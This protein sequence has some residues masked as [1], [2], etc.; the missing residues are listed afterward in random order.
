MPGDR[1]HNLLFRNPGHG[2]H[3]LKVKLVGT[4]TNRAGLGARIRADF[5]TRTGS[6]RSIYRQIGGRLQLRG[7][8][9]V[10][11]IG[12]GEPPRWTP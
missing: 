7:S 2:R 1:A 12:L 10:E 8:S 4:R 6:T 11:H 5:T 3:W 9:L